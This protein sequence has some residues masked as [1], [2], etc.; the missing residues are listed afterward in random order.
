MKRILLAVVVAVC[1][2]TAGAFEKWF[3]R[4][5]DELGAREGSAGLRMKDP[6]AK[7]ITLPLNDGTHVVI[8]NQTPYKEGEEEFTGV[9]VPKKVADGNVVTRLIAAAKRVPVVTL[10]VGGVTLY[11]YF[12][13]WDKS[14]TGL[15][16]SR[17]GSFIISIY[18]PKGRVF[19]DEVRA[20]LAKVEFCPPADFGVESA[21]KM[22]GRG[23]KLNDNLRF[24]MLKKITEKRPQCVE[25]V[26]ALE[27]VAEYTDHPDTVAW[28]EKRL[29][30]LNPA[31]YAPRGPNS[32]PAY[33]DE[34]KEQ[35]DA[36]KALISADVKFEKVTANIPPHGDVAVAKKQAEPKP[37]T[38][39]TEQTISE[40]PDNPEKPDNQD[41]PEKPAT[42]KK[43]LT[44]EKS[45]TP[46]IPDTPVKP[47]DPKPAATP[48]AKDVQPLVEFDDDDHKDDKPDAAQ[49]P[50]AAPKQP[51]AQRPEPVKT[52]PEE[53]QVTPDPQ[54]PK[55][56]VKGNKTKKI[57]LPGGEEMELVWCPPGTFMMGS[58]E[59]EKGR[60][61]SNE[62]QIKVTLTKGFWIG[63]YEVTQKQYKSVMGKNPSLAKFQNDDLPVGIITWILADE[64]CKKVGQGA[65]L[66]TSAE[67]EYA[68]RAGTTTAY[69]WGDSCNGKEANCVGTRP[70]GTEEQGPDLKRP[71]KG[72]SYAPNPW[73]IC[74]MC[75]N[76]M[77]WCADWE[78]SY[79]SDVKELVDPKGSAERTFGRVIRG[80]SFRSAA[81]S[82]R[83]AWNNYE[84]AGPNCLEH[85][86]GFRIVVDE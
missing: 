86:F 27:Y 85:D 64:F 8:W 23:S 35:L 5:P 2:M 50:D 46:V 24:T 42:P 80:G 21:V 61:R 74:D 37:E 68:C 38:P 44:P 59:S 45:D 79:D 36:V 16:V 78:K 58:P 25:L 13:N 11:A 19:D 65:R 57:T 75:G 51:A 52:V 67:W 32:V 12:T 10:N 43:L 14:Y 49:K 62:H 20:L 47:E 69:P 28:C 55:T 71:V 81:G 77:E 53:E 4:V 3:M 56:D 6:N 30:R 33:D 7:T 70:C 60:F 72:G 76:M 29:K 9:G 48:K 17:G 83:S 54:P 34:D 1:C 39:K 41:T 15:F 22:Y 18:L 84:S 63:K 26:E 82:C 66:P 31:V 40:K 73:G